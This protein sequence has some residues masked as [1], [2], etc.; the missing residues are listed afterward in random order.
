MILEKELTP[1]KEKVNLSDKQISLLTDFI[2]SV[3]KDDVVRPSYLVQLLHI[4]MEES[5]EILAFLQQNKK[6]SVVTQYHCNNC[7]AWQK[8]IFHTI[9]EIPEEVICENCKNQLHFKNDCYVLFE[10]SI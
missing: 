1:I 2:N 8:K 3:N 10:K 6:L 4:K 9:G 7:N 5:Y